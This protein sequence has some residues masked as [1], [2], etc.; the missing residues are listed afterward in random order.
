MVSLPPPRT[1]ELFYNGQWNTIS[2]DARESTSVS[3][4]RGV[5]SEGSRAE[6]STATQTLDNRRG[7]Y[8]PRDPNSALYGLIGRNTPWRF[9]VNAGGPHLN[10]PSSGIYAASTPDAAGLDV[11]GDIDV[12]IDVTPEDWD[13]P[14][15]LALRWSA[16]GNLHWAMAIGQDRR[17]WF[18]WSPTGLSAAIKY[19]TCTAPVPAAD[20]ERV[21]LRATLDVNNGASGWTARFYLARHIDA[22]SWTQIGDPVTGAGTTALFNAAAALHLGD[23]QVSLLP[24]SSSGLDRFRGRIYGLQVYSGIG[25]TLKVDLDLAR[26][27][28]PGNTI[29]TDDTGFPWTISG[30]ATLSN[31]HVRMVGEI[32]AWPPEQDLSG[33]DKT[34][35]ITP[36]GIMRRLDAG[37]RP[38]DSALLRFIRAAGPIACWPLTDGAQAVQGSP[39]TGGTTPMTPRI[40]FGTAAVAWAKGSLAD[41]IEPVA[42]LPAETDGTLV[43]YAPFDSSAT[44]AWSVDFFRSGVGASDSLI[45]GDRGPGSDADPR[46]G[47]NLE[48]N[49]GTNQV[50]LVGASIGDTSSS[51]SVLTTITNAGI[52]DANPH[53]IRLTVDPGLTNSIWEVYLDGVLRANGVY[54]VVSK[55]VRSLRVGWFQSALTNDAPSVGYLTYWGANGPTAADVYKAFS[56]FPGEGAGTRFLRVCAEAEVPASLSGVAADQVRLGVQHAGKFLDVLGTGA[57]SDLGYVLEQRDDRALVYRGHDTLY[58][59]SPTITLDFSQGLISKPFR[60]LDDDKLTEN[61]VTVQRHG[62]GFGYAV[63]DEGPLSVQDPPGG[64]GRYDVSYTL[65]LEDDAQPAQLARWLLHLGTYDGLRYTKLTLNLGNPRVYAMI[66]DIYRAD[67]GDTIRLTNLPASHGPD[68]V[69]LI[70]R[71]Y[72]E[73]VGSESWTL[74]FTCQPGQPWQ[75]GVREDPAR[76]R[77]DT[78]GSQLMSSVTSAATTLSVATTLGPRWT[79]SGGDMPFDIFVGGERMTVTAVSGASSPQTFTVIR[80]INGITKAHPGGTAVRLHRPSTRAL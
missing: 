9:S 74:T 2:G 3:L 77:R 15:I 1:T 14:Q 46:I 31:R 69:D 18:W 28:A 48:F 17:L 8:S 52:F 50:V 79:T 76:G 12:R 63:L 43:G 5:S 64:V 67:V 72:T 49:A 78:A 38:L 39:L 62:G 70:I 51:T 30:V 35:S 40:E 61:D 20:G 24:D 36:T 65:S 47:W 58:N 42:Q 32:P 44:A 33:N 16:G 68:D 73:D 41:W 7:A 13:V 75:V 11:L 45:I 22:E 26:N 25:G 23:N 21:T 57:K 34:V 29:F 56:G 27:A 59:Q 55:D 37:N 10:C 66:N 53:H 71:G 54:S 60:P 80:S 19:A 4:T 6:P